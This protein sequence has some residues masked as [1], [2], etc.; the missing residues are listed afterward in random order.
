MGNE[1]GARR[2]GGEGMLAFAQALLQKRPPVA[3]EGR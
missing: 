3:L 2:T 1:R